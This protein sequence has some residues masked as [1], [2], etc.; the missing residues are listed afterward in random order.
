M[1]L[2]IVSVWLHGE[3]LCQWSGGELVQEH[4]GKVGGGGGALGVGIR[5]LKA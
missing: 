1:R 4:A 3:L 2:L 5:N